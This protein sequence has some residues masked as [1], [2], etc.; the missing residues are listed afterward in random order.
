MRQEHR[1]CAEVYH[2]LYD[3]MDHEKRVLF[4]LD[5]SAAM[6]AS[7]C[8]ELECATMPDLCFSFTGAQQEL[9][10]EAKIMEKRRVKL[11]AGQRAAW[12]MGGNG[13]AMPHLWIGADEALTKFWLW[14]HKVF[15]DKIAKHAA[16]KGDILVFQCDDPPHDLSLKQLV[17]GIV[18]WAEKNGFKP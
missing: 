18:A 14:D 17:V 16:S 8:D 15:S 5:G 1:F 4:C 13:N 10:I 3:L 9:R 2:K 7:K 12:C 6:E 11:G